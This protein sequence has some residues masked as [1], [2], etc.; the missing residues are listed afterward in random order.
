MK[1]WACIRQNSL[2][3]YIKDKSIDV[4]PVNC[5]NLRKFTL[6]CNPRQRTYVTVIYMACVIEEILFQTTTSGHFQYSHLS[7]LSHV[8]YIVISPM[9]MPFGCFLW[10]NCKHFAALY[11]ISFSLPRRGIQRQSKPLLPR[12]GV[13]TSTYC[14]QTLPKLRSWESRGT[15]YVTAPPPRFC[16]VYITLLCA[17]NSSTW[18]CGYRLPCRCTVSISAPLLVTAP[19]RKSALMI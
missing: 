3:F 10:I 18:S 19:S 1:M 11:L 7:E 15:A 2:Y 6:T 8:N 14:Q 13:P 17:P 4:T 9:K 16:A 5:C 12:G